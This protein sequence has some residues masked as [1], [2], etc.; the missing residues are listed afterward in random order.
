MK[1]ASVRGFFATALFLSC[2]LSATHAATLTILATAAENVADINFDSNG[3]VIPDG[4][5]DET[6][7]PNFP[8][9]GAG[10]NLS[11]ASGHNGAAR[12]QLEFSLAGVMSP[13]TSAFLVL[14]SEPSANNTL[15]TTFFHVTTDE[16]G[17]VTS[18]DFQSA[19]VTTGI[20]QSVIFPAATYQY[21]MT[22][23]VQQDLL[24]GNAYSSY[25]GRVN[26]AAGDTFLRGMEF[27]SAAPANGDL[28]PRLIIETSEI[29]EPSTALLLLA[30]LTLFAVKRHA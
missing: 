17:V 11:G 2:S 9:I 30:G 18:D 22:S 26:E 5:G 25:Q 3:P 4:L 21:D 28:R 1:L 23:F 16:E 12:F 10:I 27:Y 19:A 24:A 20:V 7:L 15:E 29:P 13:I 8:F 14:D 6:A